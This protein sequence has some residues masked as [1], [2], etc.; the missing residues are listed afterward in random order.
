[1]FVPNPLNSIWGEI[2]QRF[3]PLRGEQDVVAIG[4][5]ALILA[6][7]GVAKTNWSQVRPFVAISL[8][9]LVL[10]LGL[11]LYWNGHQVLLAVPETVERL[12][13]LLYWGPPL[14]EGNIALPLPGLLLHRIVPFYASMR[15]LARFTVTLMLGVAV[16]A[17]LGSAY[18]LRRGRVG[19]MAVVL[20]G[21]LVL[22]E[23][24]IAPYSNF[25]EVSVNHR[26]VDE[27]LAHQPDGT[28]LIEYPRGVVDKI[29]MYSQ[30]QHGQQVAN[31]YMS[32]PP[33]YQRRTTG[34]LGT[35]PNSATIP[36][37]REWQIRFV[38]VSGGAKDKDFQEQVLP[39]VRSLDGLCPVE[40]FDD[41]LMYF[42]QTHVFEVFPSGQSCRPAS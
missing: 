35:W 24:L 23:G 2:S 26:T 17:G 22:I 40:S 27:W 36:L 37:L 16:L 42:N 8:I 41:G 32:Q 5:A 10:A 3:F 20:L 38:L 29:A 7:V 14:P 6:L 1:L 15:V 21:A 18:L 9:S 4:F 13:K 28:T 11:T 33:A 30:A 12:Y 31:G 39:T 25:T 19:Q 34:Q